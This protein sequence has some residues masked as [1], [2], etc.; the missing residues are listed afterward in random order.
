MK[1]HPQAAQLAGVFA[2]EA[3]GRGTWEKILVKT[4]THTHAHTQVLGCAKVQMFL[5]P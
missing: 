3:A 4:H 2:Q 5:L 1:A